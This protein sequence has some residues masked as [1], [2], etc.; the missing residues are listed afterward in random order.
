MYRSKDETCC[1]VYDLVVNVSA[2]QLSWFL[3][4]I[5]YTDLVPQFTQFIR[6]HTHIFITEQYLLSH[7]PRGI[8]VS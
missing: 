1:K 7:T 5:T 3:T 2:A 8:R 6:G 4:T